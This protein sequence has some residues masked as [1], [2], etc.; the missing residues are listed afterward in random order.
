MP[1]SGGGTKLMRTLRATGDGE[2]LAEGVVGG[3]TEDGAEGLAEGVLKMST[4]GVAE[5][6]TAGVGASCAAILPNDPIAIK[7]AIHHAV[8]PSAVEAA[9]QRT[10]S[11]RP[12]FPF[13]GASLEAWRDVSAWLD[14]T[15]EIKGNTANSHSG[16]DYR[17]VRN[18]RGKFRRFFPRRVVRTVD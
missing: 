16:K 6:V 4:E 13:R 9:T 2:A 7:I 14:M 10:E 12:G 1:S 15:R 11:E 3:T 18:P 17:A 8:I 5:G